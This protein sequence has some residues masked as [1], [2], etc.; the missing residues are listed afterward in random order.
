[1]N[2]HG[3]YTRL[4]SA[5]GR[6]CALAVQRPNYAGY[7][8]VR[9]GEKVEFSRGKGPEKQVLGRAVVASHP[10]RVFGAPEERRGRFLAL[11]LRVRG[12]K[13]PCHRNEWFFA[14]PGDCPLADASVTAETTGFRVTLRTDAPAF[15]VWIDAPGVRGEFSDNSF[16]LLPG[17]PRTVSFSPKGAAAPPES[18]RAA[19]EVSYLPG[20]S[21]WAATPQH[22]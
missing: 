18:F 8:P 21:R 11:E 19:L 7:F 12:E 1:M 9:V 4:E 17:E 14:P 15:F 2:I 6:R 16:T 22:A 13:G 5:G 10:T 3:N 20:S